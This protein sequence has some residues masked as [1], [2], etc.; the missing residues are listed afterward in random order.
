M[1][2]F[3]FIEA[4]VKNYVDVKQCFYVKKIIMICSLKMIE[5]SVHFQQ[6]G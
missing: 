1:D 3:F 5:V 6:I 4:N 2:R